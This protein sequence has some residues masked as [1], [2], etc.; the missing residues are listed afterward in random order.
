MKF[1]SEVKGFIGHK[2]VSKSVVSALHIS[3][4]NLQSNRA[5][6]NDTFLRISRHNSRTNF[7]NAKEK[8]RDLISNG[9]TATIMK[10][11]S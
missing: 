7:R 11:A 1:A 6:R 3:S 10:V 4:E 2:S 8:T 9:S 5:N